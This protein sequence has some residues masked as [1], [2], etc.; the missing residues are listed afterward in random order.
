MKYTDKN[1]KP[2]TISTWI[3]ANKR[4]YGWCDCVIRD[5]TGFTIM[6]D[7]INY[8]PARSKEYMDAIRSKTRGKKVV[9]VKEMYV[10]GKLVV[11]VTI[12]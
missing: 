7:R 5:T 6:D 11:T 8:L 4:R 3:K 12:E 2:Y 1:G 9:D 10:G